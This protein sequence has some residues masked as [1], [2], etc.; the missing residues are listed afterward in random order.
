MEWLCLFPPRRARVG[1]DAHEVPR[2]NPGWDDTFE[3]GDLVAFEPG[4]YHESLSGGLR[5]ENN[6]LITEDGHRCPIPI[7]RSDLV[8]EDGGPST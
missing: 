8:L 6:Y 5:L 3:K 7:I 1:L 4:L 2:I